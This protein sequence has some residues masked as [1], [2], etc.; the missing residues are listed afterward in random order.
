MTERLRKINQGAAQPNL[1]TDIV[2]NIEVPLPTIFE[3]KAIL[4]EIDRRLSV[5]EELEATIETNLKRAE[6]LRQT[7]LQRAFTVGLS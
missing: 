5:T 3:Q 2:R 1:N 7:I 4:A 6:R